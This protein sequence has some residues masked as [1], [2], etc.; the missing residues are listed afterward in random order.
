VW[1]IQKLSALWQCVIREAVV[2]VVA[3]DLHII[4]E[5]H[6]GTALCYFVESYGRGI[7]ENRDTVLLAA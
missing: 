1:I 2:S 4:E 6:E 3:G 7:S 5:L